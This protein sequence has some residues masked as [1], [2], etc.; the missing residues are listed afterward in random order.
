M[1]A[2]EPVQ[3]EERADTIVSWLLFV[4]AFVALYLTE[5]AVGFV[6]DESFYFYAGANHG[7][8]FE[9]LFTH[10]SAAFD[11]AQIVRWF[12]YNHEHPALMKDLYGIFHWV[13]HD[14][15]GWLGSSEAFRVPAFLIASLIA[16]L[17]YRMGSALYGRAAGLFAAISFFLIP[18]QFF[19]AHLSAFDVPVAAMW[20]LVVYAFWRAQHRRWWFIGCGLAFGLGLATKHNTF[21][22]P[23]ALAP[24]ALY[25]AWKH[26]AGKPEARRLAWQFVGLYLGVAGLYALLVLFMGPQGFLD[27]FLLLSPQ[28]LLYVVAV[29][30]GAWILR[31]LWRVDEATFRPLASAAAMLTLGPVVLYLCW[32]YLWHHP[33]DR[34]AWWLNFHLAHNNYAWF[35]LGTLLREPPFPL[36]YVVVVTALT[37]PVSL[38]V[39]MVLGFFTVL[40]RLGALFVSRAK[41]WVGGATWQDAL[42]LVNAI[43]SIAL[44]SHP[45]VP[46]FGGVKHWF[47]SMPFLGLLGGMALAASAAW[48]TKRVRAVPERARGWAVSG[49]LMALVFVPAAI[50]EAR[51]HP[52]GTSFY[53][54]L[55]GGVPGGATLGMQR[56]FWSNNVTGVLPWINEHAPRNAR[57]W[58]HEVTPLA[59]RYYQENGYLRPDLRMA[60]GPDDSEI[61]AY[62]YHQEFREQEFA[63]WQAYGTTKP[64]MGLYL[65]ETPQV[66]VYR[67][68]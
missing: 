56:Q 35:Y 59:F 65:D 43:V 8:W 12:D 41:G 22:L 4:G 47:P 30:G 10:P 17:L 5:R 14:K 13:L 49:A 25:L 1:N 28:T 33:V 11:D 36:A 55:A 29:A 45:N 37:V 66:M 57:V 61:A 3:R 9:L 62:Q 63:I 44:I 32:P 40:I 54:E 2:F 51:V 52:Y 58:L 50:A 19:N 39:P 46:H 64:E 20:L 18:R 6:R 31:Q 16:P 26:S 21:F 15:L 67:R 38:F 53:S 42:V 34:V 23:I 7:H 24:F 60:N 68:R 48:L 27:R